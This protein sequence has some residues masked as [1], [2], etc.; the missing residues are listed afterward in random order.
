MQFS[1]SRSFSADLFL[2]NINKLILIYCLILFHNVQE[3]HHQ[4]DKENAANYID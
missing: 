1:K 2:G 3:E 4:Y